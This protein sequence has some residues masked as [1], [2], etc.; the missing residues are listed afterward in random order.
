M[1]D[2]GK[3]NGPQEDDDGGLAK[4]LAALGPE[5]CY[6]ILEVSSTGVQKL[7]SLPEKSTGPTHRR[8]FILRRKTTEQKLREAAVFTNAGKVFSC[9]VIFRSVVSAILLLPAQ[10]S[11]DRYDYEKKYPQDEEGKGMD[12]N[13]RV[14]RV[15]L[16]ESGQFDL[17]MVEGIKDTVDVMLVSAGLFSAIVSTLVGQAYMALQQDFMKVTSSLLMELIEVQRAIATQSPI[18]SIPRSSLN[19]DSPHTSTSTDRWVCGMWFTSLAISV[20]TALIAVLIKQWIQA[21]V[22]PTFGTPQDRSRVRHFRYMGMEA[23]RVPLI[24]GLLPI[25]LHLSLFLFLT[26]LIILL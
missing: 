7:D 13:A 18:A 9:C 25:L 5:E 23:W 19:L 1:D 21:Y 8:A 15:Y 6:E 17:D 16:D 26:G 24:V 22:A 20:S 12:P 3:A 14:W 11:G 4:L 2:S 10:G